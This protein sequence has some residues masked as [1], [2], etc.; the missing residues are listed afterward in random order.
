LKYLNFNNKKEQL[1]PLTISTNRLVNPRELDTKQQKQRDNGSGNTSN[2]D[3]VAC[4]IGDPYIR[5]RTR[6]EPFSA[7]TSLHVLWV[8]V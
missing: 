1:R 8:F 3:E 6:W 2:T 7:P 4:W 5:W